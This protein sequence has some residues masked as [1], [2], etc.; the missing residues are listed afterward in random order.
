[1]PKPPKRR[2]VKKRKGT[3]PN[4]AG[5]KTRYIENLDLRFTVKPKIKL[6]KLFKEYDAIAAKPIILGKERVRFFAV[7]EKIIE[8][9]SKRLIRTEKFSKIQA[10]KLGPE[11]VRRI[12][13]GVDSISKRL[14]M[15]DAEVAIAKKNNSPAKLKEIME[16]IR[17]WF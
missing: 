6:D 8:I 13:I 10:E 9:T 4:R 1:M 17:D 7:A 15:L 14:F 12:R 11:K 2:I 16:N 3:G 5:L